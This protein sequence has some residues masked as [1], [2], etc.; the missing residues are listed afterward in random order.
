MRWDLH[1]RARHSLLA[2]A[3]T[4]AW[5]AFDGVT[6]DRCTGRSD[7][8]RAL[9]GSDHRLGVRTLSRVA[10]DGMGCMRPSALLGD[11]E[12]GTGRLHRNDRAHKSVI[13][14]V[15]QG[16]RPDHR[17]LATRCLIEGA[18]D[19]RAVR[20]AAE[21]PA[22]ADLLIAVRQTGR[23]GDG[24]RVH[25]FQSPPAYRTCVSSPHDPDPTGRQPP[26]RLI[27]RFGSPHLPGGHGIG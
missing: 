16:G 6:L 5:D 4:L 8:R 7:D 21:D 24:R 15:A 10:R 17:V 27:P 12:W 25:V 13:H 26:A 9:P 14:T 2:T 22:T 3:S 1:W 11:T 20:A 19:C 23:A 18:S